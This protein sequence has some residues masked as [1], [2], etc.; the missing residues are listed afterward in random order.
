MLIL[1]A[2]LAQVAPQ[3]RDP[4]DERAQDVL[5]YD[6]RLD[7]DVERGRIEGE[8]GYRI[9]AHRPL[10]HVRLDA[11][12]PAPP[13][14]QLAFLDGQGHALEA[15]WQ[16]ESVDVAL[17]GEVKAGDEVRLVAT[18]AGQPPGGFAFA[19]NR[20]GERLAFT[21]HY[22]IRAHGWLPCVDDPADRACFRTHLTYPAKLMALASGA[23]AARGGSEPPPEGRST[24]ERETTS[25]I[26]PYMY[27]IVVG[28]FAEVRESGD[29]RLLPHLI[30]RQDVAAAKPALVHHA[31][32]LH[33]MEETFGPYA[34]GTY[35]VVQCPTRWGGFEAPGNVQ[36]S[37]R[38]FEGPDQGVGT[39][40]HELTH[41]WF[42]DAVGYAQWREVWLS[43]GF[44]SYFG[45][46]LHAQTGGPPLADTM[47]RLREAWRRSA[48]GRTKSVRWDGFKHPDFALNANTYP[49]GA[50][51]LHMLRGEL[52]EAAFFAAVRAYYREFAGRAI[53]TADFVQA[54]EQATGKDLGWFFS[55]WLDQ[56]NC[57]ELEVEDDGETVLVRQTQ[58]QPPYRFHLRLGYVDGEGKERDVVGEIAEREA[59]IRVGPHRDLQLDPRVELLFR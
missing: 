14:W 4:L 42:G 54:V 39:L 29:P 10:D 26:P 36:L 21:D 28:P 30:Y 13:S 58:R 52:G 32:W 15:R 19:D 59:R 50:W 45:P 24:L 1:A 47:R 3:A 35:R 41:M 44:A 16:G 51:V 48:D 11:R 53:T 49:K 55:Q 2:L 43:E 9:R 40:A 7:V 56:P 18:F 6:I 34:Y 27:A 8:V 12:P 33:T 37:E 23:P 17:G 5:L 25:D 20:Y 57:P 46:W 22:S 38:L 31:A